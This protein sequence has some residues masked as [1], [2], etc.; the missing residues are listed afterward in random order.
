M[1]CPEKQKPGGCQLHNL[2]CGYPVCDEEHVQ[3]TVALVKQLQ[4]AQEYT[5][6][7]LFELSEDVLEWH[8][9][10]ILHEHSKVRELATMLS[11]AGASSLNLAEQLISEAALE[12]VVENWS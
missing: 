3:N 11:F 2:Q 12:Y 10:T 6:T 8:N 9:T 1:G 7:Y 5:K 4:K